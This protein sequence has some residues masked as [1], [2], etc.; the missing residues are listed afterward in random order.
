MRS[1]PLA[2][3]EGR[4]A[5]LGRFGEMRR[6]SDRIRFK[7]VQHIRKGNVSTPVSEIHFYVQQAEYKHGCLCGGAQQSRPK[8]L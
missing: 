6:P 4:K 1:V 7:R 3:H 5:H 8:T 2:G